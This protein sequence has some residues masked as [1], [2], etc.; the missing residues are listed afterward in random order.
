MRNIAST[1][2]EVV[3]PV[4]AGQG[5][6]A[7]GR[8]HR[9]AGVGEELHEGGE[10]RDRHHLAQEARLRGGDLVDPQRPRL[11]PARDGPRGLARAEADHH[12]V[13]RGRVDERGHRPEQRVD[14]V[15]GQP[16]VGQPVDGDAP[17]ALHP[18]DD[19]ADRA[20]V[21]SDERRWQVSG[22]AVQALPESVVRRESA[23][24]E[25]EGHGAGE[26]PA[27]EPGGTGAG[28]QEGEASRREEEPQRTRG[29][30]SLEEDEA[31]DQAPRGA[32]GDVRGLEEADL[33]AAGGRV[34]LHGTLQCP[35]REAH[36]HGGDGEEGE[37]EQ[38]VETQ[39]GARA[40]VRAELEE[41]VLPPVVEEPPVDGRPRRQRR[42][43]RH[44]A[45]RHDEQEQLVVEK[46]QEGARQAHG[47]AAPGQAA[48]AQAEEVDREHGPEGEGRALHPDVHQAEPGDLERQP[49]EA[50]EGVERRPE[51]EGAGPGDGRLRGGSSA[52]R[53]A[54]GR[55]LPRGQAVAGGERDRRGH[56]VGRRAHERRAFQPEK[57]HEHP[58]RQERTRGR[59]QHVHAV[60]RADHAGG[61]R[62]VP[63]R[64]PHEEGQGHPHERRGE[65]KGGEVRDRRPRRRLIEKG[66][67][68]PEAVVVEPAAHGGEE[69]HQQLDQ[70]EE[71]QRP[72]GREPRAQ[73]A[74]DVAAQAEAGHEGGH[75]EGHGHDPDAGVQ[76]QDALPED[77]VHE[78][79]GAAQEE[80]NAEKDHEDRP[81]CLLG[82]PTARRV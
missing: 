40:P 6:P 68:G 32:A 41:R 53:L 44:R 36:E 38:A 74:P 73:D 59:P 15:V 63:H 33:A 30:D 25:Q 55:R 47:A 45:A 3:A 50:G 9:R 20:R 62:R 42:D 24:N 43:E 17:A 29:A 37:G 71:P 49:E 81:C 11:P 67:E 31:G 23:E 10:R 19:H 1:C 13:L 8:L 76:R 64:G 18:G 2:D 12:D 70:G 34:V 48:Q 60:E 56:E 35:E 78:R 26:E 21:L 51:T 69:P 82:C 28:Q 77:L 72:A 39:E 7:V 54:G 61:G 80:G 66:G 57:A 14:A 52:G 22:H 4:V 16:A 58:G 65:E 27:G 75:D 79:G 5:L 46:G